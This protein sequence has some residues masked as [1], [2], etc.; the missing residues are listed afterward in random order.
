VSEPT[1]ELRDVVRRYPGQ[2]PVESLRGVSLTIEAGELVG[3]VG[4]SGSGKTTLLHIM[5]TL[6]RATSGSVRI[7]GLDTTSMSDREVAGFR[8]MRLGFVF[9]Q[10]YLIDGMSVVD[11]VAEGLLYRGIDMRTRRQ[12]AL[13]ALERVGLA[14]RLAHRPSQLSGGER[15]RTAIARAIVGRPDLILADEPTGN[16]DS[17]SGAGIIALFRELHE[18]GATI[19]VITHNAEL[20]R[21]MTRTVHLVD[22]RIEDE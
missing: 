2:P 12:F 14:H 9:Q 8:S 15:Q 1:V 5:G 22:G 20:A 3:V 10:F 7:A 16:L 17:V 4:P 19:A 11:N 13:T 6:D 18:A 21:A